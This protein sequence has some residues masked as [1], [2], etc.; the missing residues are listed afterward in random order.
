MQQINCR[1]CKKGVYIWP[2]FFTVRWLAKVQQAFSLQRHLLLNINSSEVGI[3][4]FKWRWRAKD[5]SQFDDSDKSALWEEQHE[6]S[7][8]TLARIIWHEIFFFCSEKDKYKTI[9]NGRIHYFDCV[10]LLAYLYHTEISNFGI[11]PSSSSRRR[12]EYVEVKDLVFNSKK[13][14]KSIL[15]IRLIIA[16]VIFPHLH[17][18]RISCVNFSNILEKF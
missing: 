10:I 15:H 2:G 13:L 14:Q 12:T 6:I 18:T 8:F 9:R 16:P 17:R 4:L 11:S 1:L 7:Y 3:I 5:K